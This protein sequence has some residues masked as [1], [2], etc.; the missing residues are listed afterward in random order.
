MPP[1]VYVKFVAFPTANDHVVD[2]SRRTEILKGPFKADIPLQALPA[3]PGDAGPRRVPYS[4]VCTFKLEATPNSQSLMFYRTPG[5]TNKF[6]ISEAKGA[7]DF[8]KQ[9]RSMLDLHPTQP[10]FA[11]LRM[12]P[13]HRYEAETDDGSGGKVFLV[14][15]ASD[16]VT[17][18]DIYALCRFVKVAPFFKGILVSPSIDEGLAL[19]PPALQGR[20]VP[21]QGEH[22]FARSIVQKRNTPSTTP[23]FVV[24]VQSFHQ[25]NAEANQLELENWLQSGSGSESVVN[26]LEIPLEID[27]QLNRLMYALHDINISTRCHPSLRK[28]FKTDTNEL[29]TLA[30]AHCKMVRAISETVELHYKFLERDSDGLNTLLASNVDGRMPDEGTTDL[31]TH[32]INALRETRSYMHRFR[33]GFSRFLNAEDQRGQDGLNVACDAFTRMQMQP[34]SD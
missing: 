27:L 7:D 10:S 8:L 28:L 19:A 5:S 33:C 34:T 9:A 4:D 23:G 15:S 11:Q 16:F 18:Q 32:D 13:V 24:A 25:R 29:D 12:F 3:Q 31:E 21:L 1:C 6:V 14:R 30:H 26:A 20:Q 2:V 22:D 17:M